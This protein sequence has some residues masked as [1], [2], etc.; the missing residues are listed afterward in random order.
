MNRTRTHKRYVIQS[1][2]LR[3]KY[4]LYLYRDYMIKN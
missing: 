4:R 2:G 1:N 3:P